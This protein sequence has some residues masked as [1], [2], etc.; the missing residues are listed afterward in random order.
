MGILL[1]PW[2]RNP[3]IHLF[4]TR[5]VLKEIWTPELTSSASHGTRCWETDPNESGC[6]YT[7]HAA[8]S[9]IGVTGWYRQSETEAGLRWHGV[10]PEYRRF[11]YS[12]QM[13]QVVCGELPVEVKF[14]YE[15]TRSPICKKAFGEF[16]F[17][18][19]TNPEV[20]KTAIQDAEYGSPEDT[21]VLRKS[22]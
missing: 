1:V 14:V 2:H 17:E 8:W 11:G 6:I 4:D 3:P 15:V 20:I 22:I 19:V 12:R 21:W 10:L 16:G 7:V 5:P 13:L 18:V 9:L